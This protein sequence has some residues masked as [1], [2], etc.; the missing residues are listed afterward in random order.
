[1]VMSQ[2]LHIV[3]YATV[4]VSSDRKQN[5]FKYRTG[6]ASFFKIDIA[7]PVRID[8]VEIDDAR[9][10]KQCRSE[11]QKQLK[12]SDQLNQTI[13]NFDQYLSQEPYIRTG[14]AI[15]STLMQ[16][17]Q[18]W[19]ILEIYLNCRFK[20]RNDGSGSGADQMYGTIG[21]YYD[22]KSCKDDAQ[23]KN[24]VEWRKCRDNYI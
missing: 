14:I 3:K 6:Y 18:Y 8:S 2:Y 12:W 19:R 4:T 1:M 21:M 24:C 11:M 10:S 16:G 7:Q 22:E 13:V 23:K 17:T 15:F 5:S 9:K 20:Y